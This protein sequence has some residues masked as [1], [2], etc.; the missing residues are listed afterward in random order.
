[1]TASIRGMAAS[2][3]FEPEALLADVL[4]VEELLQRLGGVQ[5]VEDPPVLLRA[6]LGG[7]PLDVLLD[8]ALLARLLDV[9]VLDADRAAVGVPQHAEDVAQPHALLPGQPVGEE[10]PVEVPHAQAVR[11][12]VELG[13]H[14]RLRPVQRIQVGDQVAPDPVQVDEVVHL[15]LLA[16]RGRRSPRRCR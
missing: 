6:E 7:H 9:H 13:M 4:G 1:M 11:G 8:P 12:R 14:V 2:A 3:A 16:G 5:A 10:L 15:D